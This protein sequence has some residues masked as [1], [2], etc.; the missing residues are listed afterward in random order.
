MNG[1]GAVEETEDDVALG[2]V[3]ERTEACVGILLSGFFVYFYMA[4][5]CIY[6]YTYTYA[7]THE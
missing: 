7:I 1:T 5:K 6:L 2:T 4:S 3:G